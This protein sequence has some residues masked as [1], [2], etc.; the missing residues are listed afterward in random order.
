MPPLEAMASG[1]SVIVSD[2]PGTLEY[3][4]NE[5]NCLVSNNNDPISITNNINRLL[6]DENLRAKLYN[7]AKKTANEYKWNKVI[8]KLRTVLSLDN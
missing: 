2:I 6:D 8:E 4:N 5:M 3:A 7:N 1:A